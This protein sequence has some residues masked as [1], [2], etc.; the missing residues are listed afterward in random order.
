MAWSKIV[1]LY[2]CMTDLQFVCSRFS[3]LDT[4][5]L[6]KKKIKLEQLYFELFNKKFSGAHDALNDV[7]ATK[8]IY[9]KLLNKN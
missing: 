3:H 6:A 2:H 5:T 9:Y 1:T 8:K 4:L 7:E